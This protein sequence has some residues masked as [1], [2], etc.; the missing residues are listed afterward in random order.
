MKA[1]RL[2]ILI[3]AVDKDPK[4]LV[5]RMNIQTDAALVDQ[6]LSDEAK[7]RLGFSGYVKEDFVYG[8]CRHCPVGHRL[9]LEYFLSCQQDAVVVYL[10]G[11]G[12]C[13]LRA[14]VC[15]VLLHH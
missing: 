7:E 12:G 15:L 4:E 11:A 5:R 13:L 10:C 6:I 8:I 2:Q 3:S 14:D 1:K 9:D